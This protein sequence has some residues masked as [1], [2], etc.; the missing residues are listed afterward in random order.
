MGSH[1]TQGPGWHNEDVGYFLNEME[2]VVDIML[3]AKY[4]P[5]SPFWPHDR[6]ALPYPFEA[7]CGHVT[8]SVNKMGAEVMWSLSGRS[9]ELEISMIGLSHG[10]FGG[11]CY[12][13][14][15]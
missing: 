15:I 10:D 5:S 11:V 14:V 12:L 7:M 1:T 3:F 4:F 2:A 6:I 8:C 9:F 13:T